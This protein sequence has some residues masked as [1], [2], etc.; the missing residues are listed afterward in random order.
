M[1]DYSSNYQGFMFNVG[2]NV[3][4]SFWSLFTGSNC[5]NGFYQCQLLSHGI[6]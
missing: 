4:C 2:L 3:K 5:S 6:L 1:V